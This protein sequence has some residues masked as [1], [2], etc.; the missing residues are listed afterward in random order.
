MHNS[1]N[2]NISRISILILVLVGIVPSLNGQVIK[3]V[4]KGLA[5]VH[6]TKVYYEIYSP[7]GKSTGHTK[8][9]ILL[10]GAFYTIQMNW[11]QLLPMLSKTRKVIALEMQGHGHTPY[12]ER[13]FDI[14][15]LAKDV[16]GVLDYLKI[17]SADVVGYSMGGSIAY[18]FAIQSPGRLRKLVIISSTY[19][20]SGWLPE[21]NKA[22]DSFKPEFFDN[23]PMKAEY[24]KIAP[25]KSKWHPFLQQMFDFAKH[26]LIAGIPILLTLPHRS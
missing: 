23:T 1:I 4:S 24:D 7:L 18:Q 20:S 21:V 19:K 6:D 22:F 10:H 26:L 16:E 11:A 14:V 2:F 13:K 15:S 5:P 17:D 8:P 12:S 9:I 3:P 25:D